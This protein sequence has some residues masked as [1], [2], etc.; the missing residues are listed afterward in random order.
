MA[1]STIV[2]FICG[3]LL[4][5]LGV[6]VTSYNRDTRVEDTGERPTNAVQRISRTLNT[7]F[8]EQTPLLDE[9]LPGARPRTSRALSSTNA[10]SAT[11][12]NYFV[13]KADNNRHKGSYRG[14]YSCSPNVPS[15][16]RQRSGSISLQSDSV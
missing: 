11:I 2:S 8:H 12:I 13:V 4:T 16:L 5:F 6:W 14:A 7:V 15:G 9:I 3:C 10:Q 1:P